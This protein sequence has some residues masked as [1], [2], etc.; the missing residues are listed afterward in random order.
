MGES[1]SLFKS[2]N[3]TKGL[4]FDKIDLVFMNKIGSK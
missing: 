4:Y 2:V 3:G 1:L